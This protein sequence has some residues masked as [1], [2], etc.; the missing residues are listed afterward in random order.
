MATLEHS[1][2]PSLVGLVTTARVLA[3]LLFTIVEV[4]ALTVWLALLLEGSPTS[5]EALLGG[6]I[7]VVGL[8]I[9]YVLTDLT[10]NGSDLAAP[11]WTIVAFSLSEALLW[12]LWFAVA[13]WATRPGGFVLA[14]TVFAVTLVPQ[15]TVVDNAL[16]GVSPFARLLDLGTLG[17]TAVK[18]TGAT[19]W[20]ILVLRPV[21]LAD[22]N[23]V[24]ALLGIQ[25]FAVGFGVLALALFVEHTISVSY[26]RGR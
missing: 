1:E 22:W 25:P 19:V 7:L 15:H 4:A 13:N 24:E 5:G 21:Y 18:A 8:A 16:R 14:A 11:S 26:S 10:V 9:E 6:G 2:R 3:I 23:S 12:S 17:F 20:L